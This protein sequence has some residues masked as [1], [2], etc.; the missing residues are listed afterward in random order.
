MM[1][2]DG[3]LYP[4]RSINLIMFPEFLKNIRF[5]LAF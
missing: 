4:E 3:T 1:D 2:L 5:F